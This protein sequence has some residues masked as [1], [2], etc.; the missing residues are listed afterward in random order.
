MYDSRVRND[1]EIKKLADW[2]LDI[3]KIILA[4]FIAKLFETG[5]MRL[6]SG[7][8]LTGVIGLTLALWC[9]KVGLKFARKVKPA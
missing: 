4:A 6:S 5:G 8:L 1:Y 3:S 7:S 2:W 9:A